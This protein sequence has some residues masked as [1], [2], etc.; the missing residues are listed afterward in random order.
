MFYPSFTLGQWYNKPKSEKRNSNSMIEIFGNFIE[1][2][3]ESPE[4]LILGFSPSSVPLQQRW[5]NNGLSADF[6]ADYLTTFFPAKEDDPDTQ[7]KQEEIKG[8]VS[9][10]ANELLENAMKF[11]N[12][13]TNYPIGLSLHLQSNCLIF[14]ITNSIASNAVQ[15]FQHYLDQLTN[16]DT[17]EMLIAQLEENALEERGTSS[18]LGYLTMIEDYG[19]KLGWK[20]ETVEQDPTIVTVTTMVQLSI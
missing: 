1:N 3:P 4:Y 17:Q 9:Y 18:R 7:Y 19:A 5:R 13:C 14:M 16:S 8:A 20:F 2:L 12:D 11:N 15:S 10:I 6:L